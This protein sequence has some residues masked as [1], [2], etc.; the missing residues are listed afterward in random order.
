MNTAVLDNIQY[1]QRERYPALGSKLSPAKALEFK[2]VGMKLEGHV[3][4][5]TYASFS[6][7]GLKIVSA[8]RDETVRVWNAETG[9]VLQTLEGHDGPVMSA[10]FSPGG[11]NIVS[12]S[13]DKTV[14]VW[15]AETGELLQT[16]EGHTSALMSAAFS[17]GGE[18]IVSASADETLRLWTWSI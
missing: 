3:D 6:P 11:E 1:W 5:V 17:P 12:A 8:S 7:D 18:N 4:Q 13:S 14:R 9:E 15:S 16:L 2:Y 10:A